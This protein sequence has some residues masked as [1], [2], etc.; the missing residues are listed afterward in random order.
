MALICTGKA[1]C[2]CYI[3]VL[4]RAR[5]SFW[6]IEHGD[7]ETQGLYWTGYD[8]KMRD[9]NWSRQLGLAIR[10]SRKVD[11]ERAGLRT[12]KGIRITEQQE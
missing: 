12:T 1:E 7:P 4:E 8:S 9:H 11:A 10:F 6:V 2:V 3:C 5:G